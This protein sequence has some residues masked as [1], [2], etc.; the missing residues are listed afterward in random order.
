M[1]YWFHSLRAASR[2]LLLRGGLAAAVAGSSAGLA[3]GQVRVLF[4][5]NSYTLGN[6]EP[7]LTYNRANV[8]DENA[9]WPSGDPRYE[10]PDGGPAGPWSGIPGIFKKFT[11]QA[12]LNYEV[13][14]EAIGGAILQDHH[15][16]AL[17]IIRQSQ[18]DQVVL[19]ERSTVPVPVAR[20]GQP[21]LFND[22]A[23]RLEQ[24]VHIVN[25]AA[26]LYLFQTWARADFVEFSNQPY[27]GSTL[28]V[29]TQDLHAAYFQLAAANGNFA[30]VAPVGDAWLRA[31]QTGVALRD[32]FSPPA[33]RLNLW[34]SDNH[35]ASKW[36]AYLSACVLFGQLTGLD[37]RTLGPAEQ[38]A[39]D[40]D[41]APPRAVALQAV[42][43]QQLS[44]GTP[45]PVALVSVAAQ[46]LAAGVQVRWATASESNNARFEVQRSA[47][48]SSFATVATVPGKGTTTQPATYACLDQRAPAGQLYYRLR[49]VDFDGTATFSPVVAVAE[50]PPEP[51]LFPNPARELVVLAGPAATAYR[52]RTPLGQLVAQG[53]LA[54][55]TATVPLAGLAP[56]CYL[57]ELQSADGWVVRRLEKY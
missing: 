46:R 29:M 53:R 36:G 10:D 57:I 21:A 19:Q 6:F 28:E 15:T 7:V 27:T 2:R 45:L 4:V 23:A 39:V 51:A 3:Q 32:P 18:W 1:L 14:L 50:A 5:G 22:Y 13:H 43:Y 20:G 26:R 38:A 42:A 31:I 35:H 55:G 24:A 49:Q 52:V 12:G 16:H 34:A 25:P 8:I 11:T 40:L 33:G 41:I 30:A 17:G 44:G 54:N 9:G 56:G 37:P 48:G 47:N